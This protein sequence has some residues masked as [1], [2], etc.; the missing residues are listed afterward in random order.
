M[1]N[2]DQQISPTGTTSVVPFES[3]S[4]DSVMNPSHI[5]ESTAFESISKD[6]IVMNP[7][8]NTSEN[9]TA[10]KPVPSETEFHKKKVSL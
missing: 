4:K 8:S 10:P 7:S 9:S 3:A 2:Q 5:S 6:N 1:E